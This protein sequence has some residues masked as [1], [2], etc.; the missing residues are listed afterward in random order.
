MVEV[1]FKHPK[2]VWG[3]RTRTNYRGSFPI[4]R[5]LEFTHKLNF[6]YYLIGIGVGRENKKTREKYFTRHRT[7]LPAQWLDDYIELL[8]EART[9]LKKYLK[10]SEETP[11]S[12]I[13]GE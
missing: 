1:D 7:T 8:I 9:E 4:V 2:V 10:L 13:G 5:V 3:K 11:M 12:E 6:P